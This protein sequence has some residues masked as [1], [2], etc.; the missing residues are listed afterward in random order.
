MCKSSN[1]VSPVSKKRIISV[2]L[3]GFNEAHKETGFGSE[4]L[5]GQVATSSRVL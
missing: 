4:Y 2:K 5:V 3:A 1:G